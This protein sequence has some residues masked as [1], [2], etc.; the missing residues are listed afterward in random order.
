MPKGYLKRNGAW[1]ELK[2]MYVKKNGVWTNLKTAYLKKNGSWVK[3][4]SPAGPSLNSSPT[5]T[6]RKGGKL[7]DIYDSTLGS[8]DN[9]T[10]YA[11][12]WGRSDSLSGPFTD[13]SG[14][15][16]TSYTTTDNDDDKY[17]TVTVRATDAAGLFVEAAATP[18][19]I[20]KYAPVSLAA[21]TIS[22]S[23][24]V[25]S[26][27][28]AN[29]SIGTQWKLTTDNS[30]DTYPDTFAY[31]WQ[32]ADT[33]A[34]AHNNS[35]SSTYPVTVEDIG[36]TI[37][38]RVTATNTGGSTTSAWS[39]ATAAVTQQYRFSFG[40]HL[41]VGSNGYIGL[42]AGGNTAATMGAGKNVSIFNIDLQQWYLAEYS[43]TSTYSLYF[44]SYLYDTIGSPSSLNALDYQIKFYNDTAIAYCDVYIVRR[45]SNVGFSSTAPG[46]YTN[47][48][49]GHTGIQGPYVLNT[50]STMRVYFD[51]TIATTGISWNPISGNLWDLIRDDR[52][53]GLDDTY[54]DVTTAPNQ[55]APFPT[56]TTAPTLTTNTGNFSSGSRITLNTGTWT[57]AAAYDYQI[58]YAG[59]SPIPTT[60]TA[61]KTLINTNQYD[62]GLS[63]ATNPSYY[64]RGKITAYL[65]A[66]KTGNSTVAWTDTSPISYIVPG[67]TINVG[68]AT[69]TGFTISGTATPPGSV[70]ISEIYIYNSAQTLIS[71]ITTGLPSVNSTSGA[72]SY[73][74][75]GGVHSTTYYAKVQAK[76]TDTS[77]T[78]FTTAFS[79]SITTLVAK[80]PNTPTSPQTSGITTTNITFSWTAPTTDANH[81]G[82]TSY[83]Y[84]TSTSSTAPTD[85]TTPTGTT[86]V[87]VT[88]KDF[89]YTASTSPSTY[90]FWVRA[91]GL[92]GAS[93]WTTAVSGTPTTQPSA[94]TS[95]SVAITDGKMVLTYSGGSGSQYDI[96]Y[97]NSNSRPTDG[98][99][100]ADFPNEASPYT[101]TTL[102]ARGTTRWFWVRKSTGTA[103]SDWYPSGTG[104][105]GYIP[106]LTPPPPV[107]TNSA[108]GTAS[109]SWHWTKPTPTASQDEPTSW[110]YV[111][112]QS[113]SDP[114]GSGTNTTTQ[115][116][117]ASPLVTS[118][119]SASTTYY[120]HVRAKNADATGAWVTKAGTT[121]ATFT[122]PAWNG[123]MPTWAATG[124]NG[125][126][127]RRTASSLQYGWNNGTFS[128]S[129]SVGTS[130][131]WDFYYSTTQPASTT[132]V[133]TPTHTLAYSETN[134]TSQIFTTSFIYRVN[135]TYTASSVWGSIRPY[136]FGTDGNKYVR[137]TQPNGTWS[138]SI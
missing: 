132:T 98:Q 123:T 39:T 51:G 135:P 74:W 127:F 103:R 12:Q 50:G 93:A 109:L 41:Y 19:K 24:T 22:G 43:D 79:S 117:A 116:T 55:S 101:A 54:T 26:T 25:D 40:K 77:G 102:T 97:A 69:K 88:T 85:T 126:N 13:I 37:A 32:W 58:A 47:G 118:S 81:L 62:I 48:N 45:G 20:V 115:P 46:F 100:F 86:T 21:Y 16:G 6:P 15:T 64:F 106:L 36:H 120:L 70:S 30:S 94:P 27:L 133:R 125:S 137:G 87:S 73:T 111:I 29:A 53:T 129:G 2:K 67:T 72:W 105:T 107:I 130:K 31:E 128:F 78:T 11:R 121:T 110:D 75:T 80:P 56:A 17:I 96:Y 91:Q 52:P 5:I 34:E 66:D 99:A 65:N 108:A 57:N 60:T 42:E 8:W 84:Y 1:V 76:S 134:S 63:D 7:Y 136:Q 104:V 9:A 14:A 38:V 124:S 122:T 114:S 18:V 119:L 33:G 95:L 3:I 71:T 49:S 68:T 82:P 35:N 4:F 112:D 90:Y 23:P 83:D 59:T 61:F 10:T 113:S 89:T 28:T 131:G 92:D 44:R 138:A